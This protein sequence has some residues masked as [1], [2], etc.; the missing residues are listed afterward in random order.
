MKEKTELLAE[1]GFGSDAERLIIPKDVVDFLED[2]A[3][4]NRT[5]EGAIKMGALDDEGSGD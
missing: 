1:D 2:L 5:D 3:L 4:T